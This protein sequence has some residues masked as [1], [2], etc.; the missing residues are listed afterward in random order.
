MPNH[1]RNTLWERLGQDLKPTHLDRI[2]TREVGFDELPQTFDSY[3]TGA[4]PG[5]HWSES[6]SRKPAFPLADWPT[7]TLGTWPAMM[8]GEG[9]DCSATL[10]AARRW[11]V[12][13]FG[14]HEFRQAGRRPLHAAS[15]A[16]LGLAP[17]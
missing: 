5:G 12:Q 17:V 16:C 14:P 7:A 10:A 2:V 13:A 15:H 6:V 11:A 9:T 3:L 1:V 4:M 8:P